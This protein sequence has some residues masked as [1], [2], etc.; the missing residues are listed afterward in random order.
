MPFGKYHC[1]AGPDPVSLCLQHAV[2]LVRQN[3][4][5]PPVIPS[6]ST[7]LLLDDIRVVLYFKSTSVKKSLCSQTQLVQVIY[8]YN[9][10]P[11]GKNVLVLSVVLY[12]PVPLL[13][14]AA[15]LNM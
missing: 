3:R 8:F 7:T 5:L 4:S 9:H 12:G 11:E 14:I 6:R 10:T 1:P 2:V 13:L 15:T